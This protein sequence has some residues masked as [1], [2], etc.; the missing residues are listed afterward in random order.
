M[1]QKHI[2]TLFDYVSEKKATQ[3]E[4]ME[5]IDNCAAQPGQAYK[6]LDEFVKMDV[7]YL[8]GDRIKFTEFGKFVRTEFMDSKMKKDAQS[9]GTVKDDGVKKP[10]HTN[11]D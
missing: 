1:E 6:I 7:V 10:P 8:K 5:F 9:N 2:D 11:I 3:L 4:Y